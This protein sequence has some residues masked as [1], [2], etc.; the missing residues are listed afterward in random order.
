[1]DLL[2]TTM[3]TLRYLF[4][5]CPM[6]AILDSC[7]IIRDILNYSRIFKSYSIDNSKS[8]VLQ[9]LQM[10]HWTVVQRTFHH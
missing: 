6:I 4:S 9:A 2:E 1:M 3:L 8:V 7:V 10:K 5:L